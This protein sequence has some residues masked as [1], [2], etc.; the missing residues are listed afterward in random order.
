MVPGRRFRE[1]DVRDRASAA[2]R[3]RSARGDNLSGEGPAARE[4][5]AAKQ[6][7][8]DER[9]AAEEAKRVVKKGFLDAP[10]KPKA[11]AAAEAKT[12]KEAEGDGKGNSSVE[13][14]DAAGSGISSALSDLTLDGPDEDSTSRSEGLGEDAKAKIEDLGECVPHRPRKLWR[15]ARRSWRRRQVASRL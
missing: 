14:G 15:M 2:A 12:D 1:R 10:K 9:K 4:A 11:A 13:R 5:W 6:K 3:R 8:E 7:A